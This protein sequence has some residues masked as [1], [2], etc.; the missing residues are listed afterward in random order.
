MLPYLFTIGPFRVPTH[1]FFVALGT[2]VAT[3]VFVR[4]ALRR[5]EMNEQLFGVV[6]GALL[7][8]AAGAKLS[9]LGLYVARTGDASWQGILVN[10]GK[11]ILGG[12]AG[13]YAGALLFKWAVGYPRRT[14]DLFAPA[15]AL[16]MAVGRVGCLLTEQ[17]GT[18]TTLPWGIVLSGTL[19]ARTPRCPT[20]LPGDRLH[21][22]F[23]YEILF[24]LAMFALIWFRLRGVPPLRHELLKVY[25]LAYA[26]FR[27]GVEFVRGNEVVWRGLTR[28]QIFLIP[29]TLLLVAYFVRRWRGGA[30]R[31][32]AAVAPI[33]PTA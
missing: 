27:F 26:V 8:G 23:V 25:L 11:S 7:C 4:E 31:P 24:H 21:P 5:R 12:L 17:L 6:C 32:A 19:A 1:G 13:A 14:G 28:S 10:G 9:T 3:V 2:A 20:C 29:T 22:S 18:P 33:S 15:I 16:G 30:F